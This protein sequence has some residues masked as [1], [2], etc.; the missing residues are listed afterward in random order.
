ME[1][2]LL[3]L[4]L[5]PLA[6]LPE[7]G[8]RAGAEETDDLPGPAPTDPADPVDD[9][10]AIDLL[11]DGTADDADNDDA[12]AGD[13]FDDGFD[14][15]SDDAAGDAFGDGPSD[16]D[17]SDGAEDGAGISDPLQ[18]VI[19]DDQPGPPG[20]PPDQVLRPVDDDDVPGDP[21][22]DP[23]DV[24]LPVDDIATDSSEIWLDLTG[25]SGIGHV[26]VDG[27]DPGQDILHVTLGG[28]PEGADLQLQVGPSDDGA[29]GLVHVGERLIA[30]LKG[31]PGATTADIRISVI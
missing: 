23:E 17:G 4:G 25:D 5:I 21:A 26:V 15:N 7:F 8:A 2:A 10:E 1:F 18:P 13:G 3:L 19:A 11:D 16:S 28:L 31:A 12:D 29:D 20:P 27:F 24:L 9:D 14:D 30:V 22:D 6:F